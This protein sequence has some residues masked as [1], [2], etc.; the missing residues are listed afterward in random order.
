MKKNKLKEDIA[1][2][3]EA[4]FVN[5]N[6][7]ISDEAY[8]ALVAMANL[9]EGNVPS[10]ITGRFPKVKHTT[11]MLSLKKVHSYEEFAKFYTGLTKRLGHSPTFSLTPKYD[12]IALRLIYENGL[13]IKAVTR[14]DGTQGENIIRNVIHVDSIPKVIKKGMNL[15]VTG[16]ILFKKDTFKCVNAT[17]H[18]S[19]ARNAVSGILRSHKPN[20]GIVGVLSFVAYKSNYYDAI[21]EYESKL[22]LRS[23][24]FDVASEYYPSYLQSVAAPEDYFN[25][26]I[27]K[28]QEQSKY[29]LDGMVIKVDCIEDQNKLGCNAKYPRYAVAWKFP[30][31]KALT[32]VTNIK[33]TEGKTGKKT[34]VAEIEPIYLDN[35]IINSVSL[36]S[37]KTMKAKD[38][39]IGDYVY[40]HRAGGVIPQI[41]EVDKTKRRIK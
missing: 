20:L 2:H 35:V 12:G 41:I 19:N 14:G 9:G 16:E 10:D 1:K 13:L 26:V 24:G 30:T 36:N 32:K 31:D 15:E 37:I 40:V 29:S 18:Y 5:D 23:M 27:N 22:N 25:N 21:T 8:D 3:D 17:G 28:I 4:Y 11:P 33:I 6:P 7:T 34:P 38:I 39:R